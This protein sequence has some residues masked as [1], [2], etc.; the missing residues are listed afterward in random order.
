[1]P[2]KSSRHTGNVL[3]KGRIIPPLIISS[4][5]SSGQPVLVDGQTLSIPA[6]TAAARYGAAV[7][8]DASPHIKDR[9]AKSRKAIVSK[10]VAQTS[11]YGVSTGF[12]GSGTLTETWLNN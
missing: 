5:S 12:G 3:S 10:V 1:M 6:V 7:S 9:V 4:H 11:I 2:R 8:L